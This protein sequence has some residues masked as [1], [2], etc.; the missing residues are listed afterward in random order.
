[1]LSRRSAPPSARS[2]ELKLLTKLIEFLRDFVVDKRV[3]PPRINELDACVSNNP[4]W[5]RACKTSCDHEIPP[6]TAITIEKNRSRMSS[7]GRDA[8]KKDFALPDEAI[9]R[10][11]RGRGLSP[12]DRLKPRSYFLPLFIR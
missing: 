12:K 2:S 10:D 11:L 9:V 6:G 4:H 1:M 5:H 8:G 7:L 3:S